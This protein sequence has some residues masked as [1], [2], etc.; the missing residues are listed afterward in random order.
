VLRGLGE[1]R[2]VE[3]ARQAR[4]RPP[5]RFAIALG[6]R[7]PGQIQQRGLA[8]LTALSAPHINPLLKEVWNFGHSSPTVPGPPN[9]VGAPI[10]FG[11]QGN[12]IAEW[13]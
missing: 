7:K 3:R 5:G 2:I 13:N 8:E 6:Q 9:F 12:I 1:R 10:Y 11:D 4:Q